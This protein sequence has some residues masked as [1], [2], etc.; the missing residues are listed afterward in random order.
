MRWGIAGFGWVASDYMAPG[1]RAAN[2]TV[3]SVADPSPQARARAEALGLQAFETTEAMLAAG[4][5]DLLYVASPNDAH[6]APVLAAAAAGVPVLCEKPMAATIDEAG[7][8]AEA[9][10]G[11]TLFGTAFDQRYHP[12]HVAMADAIAGG[13]IG[14]PVAVRIVY[15][16][17]VDPHWSPG[18]D[19]HDNWRADAGRAGGGAVIDLALHGLD[20]AERLLGEPL[21]TLSIALQR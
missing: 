1:I 9:V 18:G 14:R 10:E 13:S 3:T 21:A 19:V 16:C 17:W 20:L 2:G 12:A 7:A 4:A 8:I 11:R 15:A 6:L 5:C